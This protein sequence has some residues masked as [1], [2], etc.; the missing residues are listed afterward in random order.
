MYI[1]ANLKAQGGTMDATQ[2]EW[3]YETTDSMATVTAANYFSD[4]V[5]RKVRLG[6]KVHIRVV[7][8]VLNPTTISAHGYR[9]F[10]AV[11]AMAATAGL[12][13]T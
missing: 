6:D 4:A 3:T 1:S 2:T 7:D 12:A 10:S 8:N 13:L 9:A 5:E 11:G